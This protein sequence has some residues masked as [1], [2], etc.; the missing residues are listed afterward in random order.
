MWGPPE[1]TLN[2]GSLEVIRCKITSYLQRGPLF[3][4]ALPLRYLLSEAIRDK[5]N[6]S[7]TR[8]GTIVADRIVPLT[9]PKI[10]SG[11]ESPFIFYIINMTPQFV[12][13]DFPST[14]SFQGSDSKRQSAR[15][16]SVYMPN[17]NLSPYADAPK[18][19]P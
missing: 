13:I 5:N 10:D 18:M 2:V 17:I 19:K 1:S 4:V 11:R 6:P 12:E 16:I 14:V 7:A 9:L 8:G 3:N 15:L